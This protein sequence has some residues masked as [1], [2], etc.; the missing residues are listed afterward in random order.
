MLTVTHIN[1]ATAHSPGID[2]N[3]IFEITCQS[4]IQLQILFSS[5]VEVEVAIDFYIIFDQS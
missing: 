2:Q 5:K 4:Q 3:E 1:V